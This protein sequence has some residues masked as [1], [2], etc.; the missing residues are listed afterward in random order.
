MPLTY[1]AIP[2]GRLQP[3]Q[4]IL[5]SDAI[6]LRDNPL[7]LAAGAAG[8]PQIQTAAINDAAVTPAKIAPGLLAISDPPVLLINTMSPATNW[9]D[10]TITPGAGRAP[11][12]ALIHVRATGEAGTSGYIG[13]I[14]LRKNGAAA[15]TDALSLRAVLKLNDASVNTLVVADTVVPILL[16]GSYIFE[17][18]TSVLS[19]LW[20]EFKFT[21]LGYM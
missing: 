14:Y 7:A 2:D 5:S 17:Y 13:N 8:A 4:K 10:V 21:L 3:D 9:T 19:G 1:T 16:D 15:W 11:T 18:K 12:M 6:L 20:K